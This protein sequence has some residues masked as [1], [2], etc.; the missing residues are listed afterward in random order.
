MRKVNG[1]WEVS[2]GEEIYNEGMV[3]IGGSYM[4][5][6]IMYTHEVSCNSYN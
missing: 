4:C 3:W 1:E 2:K 6:I 5:I